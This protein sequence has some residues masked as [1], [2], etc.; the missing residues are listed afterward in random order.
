MTR[1]AFFRLEGQQI[2]EQYGR[3]LHL[4][5][6]HWMKTMRFASIDAFANRP[7]NSI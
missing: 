6:T 2:V 7:S 1:M 5:A 3:S 4:A